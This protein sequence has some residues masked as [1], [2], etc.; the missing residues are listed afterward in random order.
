MR[1][2]GLVCGWDSVLIVHCSPL[3]AF[4]FL[5][6]LLIFLP[7]DSSRHSALPLLGSPLFSPPSP[8]LANNGLNRL[9]SCQSRGLLWLCHKSARKNR[10]HLF[11]PGPERRRGCKYTSLALALSSSRVHTT[12]ELTLNQR[13][14]PQLHCSLKWLTLFSHNLASG[15]I[16]LISSPAN[17][18]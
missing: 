3:L 9:A 10:N 12:T 4:F 14:H 5:F 2:S 7:L 13:S 15:G 16:F 8:A 18:C 1:F 17:L 6:F 11:R